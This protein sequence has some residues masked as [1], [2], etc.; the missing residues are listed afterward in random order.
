MT[1]N[2]NHTTYLLWL[3]DGLWH[4]FTRTS[5]ILYEEIRGKPAKGG[6]CESCP[7]TRFKLFKS[8]PG[9]KYPLY[10]DVVSILGPSAQILHFTSPPWQLKL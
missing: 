3:G 2:G 5:R 7:N 4:C 8:N 9:L 10:R 1:A 6:K